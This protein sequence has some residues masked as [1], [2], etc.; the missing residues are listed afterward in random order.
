MK[1]LLDTQSTEHERT[2]E[3]NK[4]KEAE[5]R[6]LRQQ[7]TKVTAELDLSHRDSTNM[8]N[9]LRQ[10]LDSSQRDASDLLRKNTALEQRAKAS[11]SRVTVLEARVEDL[12]RQQQAHDLELELVRNEVAEKLLQERAAWEKRVAEARSQFQLLEDAAVEA[13]REKDAAK[14][15]A[16]A[17]RASVQAERA[18][19]AAEQDARRRAEEKSDQQH[20]VLADYDKI[21]GDLRAEL[22]STKARLAVAEEKAGRTVVS[23]SIRS[24][25]LSL[26][27]LHRRSSMFASS[28]K[29][30]ASRTLRWTVSATR[31]S[32]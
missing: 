10:D 1:R 5:V 32:H 9:R 2:A 28:R 7:L 20:S 24:R 22:N 8:I 23:G 21:N 12:E 29:L 14:R 17:L 11:A 15:E 18:N 30:Y 19:V 3:L 4:L 13:R 16:D 6:D 27:R 26:T 25:P 31:R